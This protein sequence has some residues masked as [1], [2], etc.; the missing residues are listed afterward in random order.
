MS[1][2]RGGGHRRDRQA[3]AELALGLDAN[4]TPAER[5]GLIAFADLCDAWVHRQGDDATR[6]ASATNGERRCR[7]N[8]V[9][10][11]PQRLME[12]VGDLA[13][14]GYCFASP[15]GARWRFPLDQD[16]DADFT[17]VDD[18]DAP[19]QNMSRF[20]LK[21]DAWGRSPTGIQDS[22]WSPPPP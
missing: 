18:V 15:Q 19:A 20:V 3:A 9:L 7:L 4:G 13:F 21:L 1:A 5:N 14:P 8:V 11:T 2:A 16:G 22:S 6:A 10:D 12:T 17:L